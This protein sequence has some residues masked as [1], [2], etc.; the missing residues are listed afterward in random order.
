M[1]RNNDWISF[2][3]GLDQD[4][5]DKIINLAK[6]ELEPADEE[7][8]DR[9]ITPDGP[10]DI[11]WTNE[12]WI[13]DSVWKYMTKANEEAGWKY[14]IGAAEPFQI[15]RY[16]RGMFY[17]WHAD[18]RGDHF[19][20]YDLPKFKVVDGLIRKLSMSAILN[21]DYEGGE[22]QTI[23]YD[24]SKPL[25]GKSWTDA[26]PDNHISTIEMKK[27]SIVIFPSDIY[28]RVTPVTKGIRY[29]LTLWFLGPPYV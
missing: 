3:N 24:H 5:C 27:G 2:P 11:V 29:S 9:A 19:A 7:F 4:A 17:E 21:D 8:H 1:I 23:K 25:T 18:G 13:Y 15:A 16:K 6:D 14:N 20:A 26:D 28:H 22:L 10:I 12:Q